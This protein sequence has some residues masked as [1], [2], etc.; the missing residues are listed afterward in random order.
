MKKF[1]K[2]QILG[3]GITNETTERV[4][5]EV[6]DLVEKKEKK[7]FIITPNPEIVMYAKGHTSY[8]NILNSAD[9]ALCD[10]V[11]LLIAGQI[12]GKPFKER[13][14]GVD[15][16]EMLC[17]NVAR[18]PVSIG[19][20]GA[21]AGVAEKV[22]QCLRE[23]YPGIN[24]IFTASEW[25]AKQL[26]KEGI[27]I[28]FVAFG[29]PKQEE[30]IIKNLPELP[31]SVAMG[32]GGAFDYLSGEVNR[33]PLLVRSIGLEWFFRLMMQPWRL[34]R[35]I[36]LPFFAWSVLQQRLR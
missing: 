35:Q 16:M 31:I 22:A 9:I 15:F 34:K 6:V 17:K 10:G 20:L 14:T 2:N 11:G 12:L 29:F 32:V 26:P 28:L 4:L 3:I 5:E 7:C 36:V 19:L 23:K 24:I 18:K 13:I 1:V 30:W 8:K 33:A 25:D 21:R 27:D